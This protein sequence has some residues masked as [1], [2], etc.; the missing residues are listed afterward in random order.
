MNVRQ[1]KV[2]Y[3]FPDNDNNNVNSNNDNNNSSVSPEDKGS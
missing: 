1:R 3:M 2:D